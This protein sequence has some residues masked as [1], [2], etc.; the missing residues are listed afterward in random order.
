MLVSIHLS[1]S[2]SAALSLVRDTITE[3]VTADF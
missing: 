3:P 1:R 2:P